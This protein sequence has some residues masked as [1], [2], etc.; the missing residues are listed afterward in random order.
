M[1]H[2][3]LLPFVALLAAVSAC[4][5]AED[6]GDLVIR[7]SGE[8]AAKQGYPFV[9]NDATI[10]FIDGWSVRFTKFLIA[11]AEPTLA[12]SDGE[13]ANADPRAVVADL[14]KGDP[15]MIAFEALAA[16]RWDRF[17]FKVVPPPLDAR[18]L[19][20][21]ATDDIARMAQGGFNYWIEGNARRGEEAY[22]FAWGLRNPTRNANCTNGLDGT[23]GFVV[24]PNTT[25]E[26]EITV[27]VDHLFWDTLGGERA[28]L[29]FDAM[30]GAAG[31]DTHI[32]FEELGLQSLANPRGPNGLAVTDTAGAPLAYNPGS[33]P[34]AAP[35]LAAFMLASA[36]SQAHVNGLGLCTVSRL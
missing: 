14:H 3:P 24:R 34:L 9:K 35:H 6:T 10:A 18:P 5:S 27:H 20:D 25:T 26:G 19:N 29:R 2:D 17:G 32:T 15:V 16:R 30:A 23:D 4:G 8:G 36:A 22:S 33:V 11:L 7:V 28:N 12:T 21:V 1:R 31:D 13:R